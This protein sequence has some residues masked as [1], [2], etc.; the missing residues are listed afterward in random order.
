M[1]GT[2]R[3]MQRP[4]LFII[5]FGVFIAIVGITAMAQ[6]LLVSTHFSTSTLNSVVGTD[7]ALVRTFVTSS[8]SPDDLGPTGPSDARRTVLETRLASLL[9]TGEIVRI[10]LRLPDGRV[11]VSSEPGA[12]GQV[13]ASTDD[14]TTALRGERATADLVERGTSEAVGPALTTSQVLREYF[15]LVTDGQVRAVVGIWRDA[16]PILARLEDLRRGIL[17]VTLSAALIVA[18]VLVFVFRSAQARISRQAA[19]LAEA[20]VRDPLTGQLNHGAVVDTVAQAVERSR[21]EGRPFGIALLDVDNFRLLNETYGHGAGD[22]V[23]VTVVEVVAAALPADAVLGRYGPDEILFVVPAERIHVIETVLQTVRATLVDHAMQFGASERL[24]VTISAGVCTFPEHADSVTALLTVA[25]LTLQEA[26]ASGGD[27]IRFAG[28]T[29][30]AAVEARTFD[31]FQGLILAVDTKDRYTKRH[32]EDVAR[33]ATFLATL[34]DASP[35]LIATV[36]VAGLLHDVGKIGV[37][38]HILRKPAALTPAEYD[39]VKQHVALGDLIIRDLPD[40]E[41]IRAGVRHHHERWDGQG[42]LDRLA[43]EEIPLIARLLAI[44]DAFSA[45]T[46][47]RPYRKALDVR[48][49]LN[50]LGDAAGSQLDERLVA[51]FIVG[52]ETA[53]DAPLPGADTHATGLWTP[54]RHVA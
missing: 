28:T 38:D 42:Y 24:P 26:K 51:A 15:P 33:Y 44:G 32:S 3:R 41:L 19:A 46:T 21:T 4:V 1:F 10:E 16:V 52:I 40:V 54:Y 31:V 48:E 6:I 34:T 13:A 8:L 25:A 12:V 17:F 20:A 45:M 27:A 2:P 14:F 5:V 22:D 39:I 36:R 35:E 18:T 50:R 37:P 7:S 47:T 11:V 9:A 23:L 43:G 53:A 29:A 49:A 30:D